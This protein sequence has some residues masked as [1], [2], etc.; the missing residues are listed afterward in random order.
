MAR[1][2]RLFLTT[3][4]WMFLSRSS[5]RRVNV[6]GELRPITFTSKA[7]FTPSSRLRTSRRDQVF[8]LFAHDCQCQWSSCQLSSVATWTIR[9]LTMTA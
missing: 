7:S 9:P 2:A 6:F 5:L 4:R 1:L 8:E 3:S